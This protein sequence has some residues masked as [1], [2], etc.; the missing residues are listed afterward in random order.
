ME[1]ENK[2][3]R[4]KV[5]L[6]RETAPLYNIP[7]RDYMEMTADEQNVVDL[8]IQRNQAELSIIE[9]AITEIAK[10]RPVPGQ[11]AGDE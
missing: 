7:H 4:M 9:A 3:R 2:L 8:R 6:E 11:I 1:T 5:S 10:L